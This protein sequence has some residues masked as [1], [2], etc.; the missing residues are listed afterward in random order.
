MIHKNLEQLKNRILRATTDRTLDRI[1]DDCNWMNCAV[2]TKLKELGILDGNEGRGYDV[3]RRIVKPY[4]LRRGEAFNQNLKLSRREKAIKFIN[5]L[6][7]LT[8]KD[9]LI[10]PQQH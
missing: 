1:S 10:E 9:I 5:D 7:P 2:G 8:K 6:I 4:Y 3:V